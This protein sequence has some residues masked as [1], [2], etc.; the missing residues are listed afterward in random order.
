MSGSHMYRG[1]MSV[2]LQAILTQA[3][4][5]ILAFCLVKQQRKLM[6]KKL[7]DVVCAYVSESEA[8]SII[9][10]T[11]K[12]A[13]LT[14]VHL[15][16]CEQRPH[17]VCEHHN[18]ELAIAVNAIL[19][20][21]PLRSN[22]ITAL[23]GFITRKW[24]HSEVSIHRL[25]SYAVSVGPKCHTLT[26]SS[27]VDYRSSPISLLLHVY[28]ELA[29]TNSVSEVSCG[30]MHQWFRETLPL[31]LLTL[32]MEQHA[33][34]WYR[35]SLLSRAFLRWRQCHGMY[36]LRALAAGSYSPPPIEMSTQAPSTVRSN[37]RE[38]NSALLTSFDVSS[39]PVIIHVPTSAPSPAPATISNTVSVP[40]PTV[41]NV[42]CASTNTDCVVGFT[43]QKSVENSSKKSTA[44]QTTTTTTTTTATIPSDTPLQIVN[45]ENVK[46]DK[47]QTTSNTSMNKKIKKKNNNDGEMLKTFIHQCDQLV[48]ERVK[49]QTFFFWRDVRL[50]RRRQLQELIHRFTLRHKQRWWLLWKRQYTAHLLRRRRVLA[51]E[52]CSVYIEAKKESLRRY[53]FSC[54]KHAYMVRRF[55]LRTCGFRIFSMWRRHFLFSLHARGAAVPFIASRALALRCLLRWRLARLCRLADRR[56]LRGFLERLRG[57][58]SVRAAGRR[59]AAAAAFAR[60]V[61]VRRRV[62]AQWRAACGS[63]RRLTAAIARRDRRTAARAL[64]K[65]RIATRRRALE[66]ERE[67]ITRRLLWEKWRRRAEM[68]KRWRSQHYTHA[69]EVYAGRLLR[70]VW[71]RWWE[72]YEKA[73]L[74]HQQQEVITWFA[75]KGH[76]N[77]SLGVNSSFPAPMESVHNNSSNT[78][79]PQR[80]MEKRGLSVSFAELKRSPPRKDPL[81]VL[82][83][84]RRL[85]HEMNSTQWQ[86]LAHS[87]LFNNSNNSNVTKKYYHHHHEKQHQEEEEGSEWKRK[88][89]DDTMVIMMPSDVEDDN[90][91]SFENSR[92]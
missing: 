87:R 67:N 2:L 40:V 12:H 84:E 54:W 21:Y 3:C 7:S 59:G 24:E 18:G 17:M 9:E 45:M 46:T 29:T 48:A 64:K 19:E 35:T 8:S 52:Q 11:G 47:I 56:F 81:A 39:T 14:A 51:D 28:P 91:P 41:P 69:E 37:L 72:R 85:L 32:T 33:K 73:R 74:Q 68:L 80:K 16:C 34:M 89:G 65:W 27:I 49:R 57:R 92:L 62:F 25:L 90:S 86:N 76:T 42:S 75:A 50:L 60:G 6:N 43:P 66:A 61:F 44:V 58:L 5:A 31:L 10:S 55:R 83:A 79:L 82:R 15:L 26:S 78:F 71:G 20:D 63:H 1:S 53:A 88:G 4:R 30:C 13:L 23:T 38:G 36:L 70:G 22:I 77:A